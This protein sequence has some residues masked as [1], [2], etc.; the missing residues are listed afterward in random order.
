[1]ENFFL[2]S[3]FSVDLFPIIIAISSILLSIGTLV[4]SRNRSK[5]QDRQLTNIENKQYVELFTKTMSD[6]HDVYKTEKDVKTKDQ[7]EL[8]ATRLLDILAVLTH[9]NNTGKIPNEILVFIKFDL[10]IGKG[11]M[12]WF[13]SHNMNQ[14]YNTST[15]EIWS[16]LNTYFEKHHV[17]SC[18]NALLPLV[19]R[20]YVDLPESIDNHE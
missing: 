16:N 9:L 4:Y 18:E 1:M 3:T 5:T 2:Q 11:V 20:N 14:K 10:T 15:Q 13:D 6:L 7:C 8:F 12:E 19:L 17:D